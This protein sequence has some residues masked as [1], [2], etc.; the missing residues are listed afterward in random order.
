MQ[1]SHKVKR[2]V[3][4]VGSRPIGLRHRLEKGTR[5]EEE[6]EEWRRGRTIN[7]TL[8]LFQL[9]PSLFYLSPLFF[10]LFFLFFFLEMLIP[11]NPM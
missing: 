11:E 3:G 1:N 4:G 5:D 7:L 6:E 9:I 8:V 2:G 10:F